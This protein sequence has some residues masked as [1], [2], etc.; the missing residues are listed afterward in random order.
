MFQYPL[1][2]RCEHVDNKTRTWVIGTVLAEEMADLRRRL[3][4]LQERSQGNYDLFGHLAT[5]PVLTLMERK[6]IYIY[7]RGNG[8]IKVSFISLYCKSRLF[9]CF[10]NTK[11]IL[12][13]IFLGVPL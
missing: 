4:V 13:I 5:Q 8:N 11:M 12:G 9:S 7:I 1:D 3:V 2:N 10:M 6:D